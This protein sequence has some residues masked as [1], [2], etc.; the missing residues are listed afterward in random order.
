MRLHIRIQSP[1]CAICTADPEH[2]GIC[3][4]WATARAMIV[5]F[6]ATFEKASVDLLRR[7]QRVTWRS[8]VL[9][10]SLSCE[11]ISLCARGDREGTSPF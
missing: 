5:L 1:V 8:P 2:P 11:A 6:P 7:L 10:L 4:R 3:G 9:A